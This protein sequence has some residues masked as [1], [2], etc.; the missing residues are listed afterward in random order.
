ML[1]KGGAAGA[2]GCGRLPAA[3]CVEGGRQPFG[4]RVVVWEKVL[5][6]DR[7]Y[8]RRVHYATACGGRVVPLGTKGG[9]V[10]DCPAGNTYKVSVTG[11]AF[12]PPTV[13]LSEAKDLG[14]N[15]K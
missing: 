3:G 7:P 8:G 10:V 12:P 2:A 14:K 13:I 9:R 1:I 4:L 15:R 5:K 6:I 11:F